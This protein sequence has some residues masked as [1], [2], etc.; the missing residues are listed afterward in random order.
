MR[1]CSRIE[2]RIGSHRRLVS[3]FPVGLRLGR[4]HELRSAGVDARREARAGRP[5]SSS[6]LWGLRPSRGR[7][8]TG[9]TPW[10]PPGA[11]TVKQARGQ[12]L[13][14]G[15]YRNGTAPPT[16]PDPAPQNWCP[17][18]HTGRNAAPRPTAAVHRDRLGDTADSTQA[19]PD[20]DLRPAEFH[21]HQMLLAAL[22]EP[23]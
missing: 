6:P 17:D 18:S 5:W 14:V 3:A 16:F 15:L 21:R 22:S 2:Y 10:K 19:A 20:A 23:E 7:A 1:A 8:L 9:P 13:Q 11:A 4:R 12:P